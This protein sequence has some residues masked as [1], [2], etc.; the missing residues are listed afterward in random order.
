MRP[1]DVS[2]SRNT[3]FTKFCHERSADVPLS[4]ASAG[5]ICFARSRSLSR[6]LRDTAPLREASAFWGS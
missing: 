5:F 3:S 4:A 6:P 2:L 1:I